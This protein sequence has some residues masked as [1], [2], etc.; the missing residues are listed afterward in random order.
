MEKQMGA[1]GTGEH[2]TWR[3]VEMPV[4]RLTRLRGMPAVD[5]T[6]A[7]RIGWINDVFIDPKSGSIQALELRTIADGDI[8][9]VSALDV[10]R[11]GHDAVIMLPNADGAPR[12]AGDT[13][14]LVN[15]SALVGL[16]VMS[17][18]GNRIGYLSDAY[19]SPETLEVDA[20][21]LDTPTW[22]QWFQGPR[23]I[24][25]ETV[26]LCSPD[27]M[28]VPGQERR[29]RTPTRLND[30]TTVAN[31]RRPTD[32]LTPENA[33]RERLDRLRRSA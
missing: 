26:L 2:Y 9:R 12:R 17:D 11:I 32:D 5:L 31:W 20:Y 27:V 16:E 10:R 14:G 22:K 23:T 4:V 15:V 3:R 7:H 29:P 21:E 18:A 8:K 33:A 6:T 24:V 1:A 28:I 13:A 19:I 25:P 30:Q